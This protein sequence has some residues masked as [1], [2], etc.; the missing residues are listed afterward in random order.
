[1]YILES[2]RFFPQVDKSKI[3]IFHQQIHAVPFVRYVYDGEKLK[4]MLSAAKSYPEDE[5]NILEL[6][7]GMVAKSCEYTE[8]H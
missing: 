4:K 3:S 8:S 5:N 6:D 7:S 1:M 2:N